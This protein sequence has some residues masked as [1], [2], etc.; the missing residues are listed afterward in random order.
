MVTG[1][2]VGLENHGASVYVDEVDPEMPPYT[3]DKT[4]ALLKGRIRDTGRFILLASKNSRDSR[5]VPWELGVADGIKTPSKIALF[6][7]SETS[8]DKSWVSWEY[9]GLYDRIAYGNHQNYTK[10]IWMVIDE[11]YNTATE[12]RVWL[13]GS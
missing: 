4:A 5:W 13:T 10:P 6:P 12:L 2:I 9:L 7:A 3:S 8:Q 11:K 1:T